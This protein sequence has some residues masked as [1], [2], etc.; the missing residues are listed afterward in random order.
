MRKVLLM[1]CLFLSLG[2]NDIDAENVRLGVKTTGHGST[3]P[4][5]PKSPIKFWDIDLTDYVITMSATSCDYTLYLYDEEGEV[6]YSVFVPAGTTQ[7]IL[8][9]TLSGDF[10][11]RFETATYYYYGYISL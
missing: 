2:T 11:L 5:G 7:V 9:T 8:P 4:E 3:I 1:M 10:E 6:A